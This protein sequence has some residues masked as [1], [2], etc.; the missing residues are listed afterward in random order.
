MKALIIGIDGL[1]SEL[2]SQFESKE[3][4]SNFRKITEISPTI[5]FRSVFPP[6][7]ITAWTSIYTGLS[8]SNHGV[9]FFKNPFNPTEKTDIPSFIY[10]KTFWRIAELRGMKV[11]TLYA[12]LPIDPV[13][14]QVYPQYLV[15]KYDVVN[16]EPLPLY[17]S[18]R[19]NKIIQVVKKRTYAQAKLGLDIY[20]DEEWDLFFIYFPDLDNV[21]HIFWRFYYSSYSE[22]GSNKSYKYKNVIPMMYKFFDDILGLYLKELKPHT[23]LIVL[24]DHGHTG[25]PYHVV[26][27]NEVLRR[28]NFLL[29]KKEVSKNIWQRIKKYVIRMMNEIPI[30]RRAAL[31]LWQFLPENVKEGF[32]S[33]SFDRENSLAALSEP[34][35]IEGLKTY[36]YGGI[37]INPKLPEKIREEIIK[38]IIK[39]FSNLEEPNNSTKIVEWICKREDIFQGTYISRYPEIIFKLKKG[40]GIGAEINSSIFTKSYS[41]KIYSGM[42]NLETPIFLI[43]LP[44]DSMSV[45]KKDVTLMDVAPTVLEILNVNSGE[46]YFDGKSILTKTKASEL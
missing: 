30:S 12:F 2:L 38:N 10:K 43:N 21:E 11:C 27:I 29:T 31:L 35:K 9:V 20:K 14:D 3:G 23:A 25:R 32:A 18:F 34:G 6:D 7:S 41:N 22:D 16:Y 36:D 26:N 19:L 33:I 28:A 8:P 5:R 40:W 1:D 45:K 37:K 42:H 24:S 17:A 4:L 46:L 44:N 13:Y 39:L 15:N